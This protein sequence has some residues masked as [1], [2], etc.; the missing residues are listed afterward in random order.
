M[1]LPN[2]APIKDLNMVETTL[3]H[4]IPSALK[5]LYDVH[6]GEGR[7]R[8]NRPMFKTPL[9][10]QGEFLALS[11]ENGMLEAITST[12]ELGAHMGA[13]RIQWRRILDWGYAR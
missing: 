10:R 4:A 13:L 7:G 8:N 11:G 9:F 1:T 3:G 2:A 12:R 6:N 5:A